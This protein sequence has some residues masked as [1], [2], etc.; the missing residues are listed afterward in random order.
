VD[1]VEQAEAFFRK[2]LGDTW[3]EALVSANAVAR[4]QEPIPE[5]EAAQLRA[6]NLVGAKRH[7]WQRNLRVRSAQAWQVLWLH[8]TMP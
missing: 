5:A 2:Q 1:E 3:K 7:N 4:L 6:V 8:D